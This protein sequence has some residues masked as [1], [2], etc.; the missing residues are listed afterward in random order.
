MYRRRA[1][2]DSGKTTL[3][4]VLAA[5]YAATS[6]EVYEVSEDAD[7]INAVWNDSVPQVFYYDDFL[8]QNTLDDKLH[9]NEDNRLLKVLRRVNRSPNKRMVMTTREYILEQARQRYERINRTDFN[10]WTCVLALGDYTS[11]VRAE[12]LYNHVYYSDLSGSDK[13]LFADPK[14]YKR[15]IG[16]ANFSPRLIDYSLRIAAEDCCGDQVTEKVIESLS[17][18]GSIWEHIVLNQLDPLSVDILVS[19]FFLKRPAGLR[20]LTHAVERYRSGKGS[21]PLREQLRR[22]LKVLEGTMIKSTQRN[23]VTLLD[24]HNPSIADYMRTYIW[25]E[26]SILVARIASV[27]SF[28]EIEEIWVFRR[29]LRAEEVLCSAEVQDA[30]REAVRRTY[31]RGEAGKSEAD[32][33]PDDEIYRRS[34]IALAIAEKLEWPDIA[35]MVREWIRSIELYD[36]APS[37]DDVVALIKQISDSKFPEIGSLLDGLL[38]E[39]I[40]YIT[41]DISDWD[42]AQYARGLLGELGDLVHQGVI[43]HVEQKLQEIAEHTIARVA[44][45]D[46]SPSSTELEEIV[47]YAGAYDNSEEYFPGLGFASYIVERSKEGRR[48]PTLGAPKVGTDGDAQKFEAQIGKMLS[49]LGNEPQ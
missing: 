22:S 15:I 17:D 2:R 6:Y 47:E 41:E 23:G 14:I 40:E 43:D 38:D 3:A 49:T 39:A 21:V 19:I 10:P 18:P 42:N 25:N 45:E 27:S 36:V 30:L 48:S 4:Q 13:A 37:G 16:H 7:E 26:Q 11:L 24:Y 28:A 33:V 29:W 1:S 34:S 12:I 9:K 8:G 35:S 32:N 5:T 31:L 44:E 46:W 20:H